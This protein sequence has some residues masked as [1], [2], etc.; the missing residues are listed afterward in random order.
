MSKDSETCIVPDCTR[1]PKYRG[2]CQA[3]YQAALEAVRHGS[4]TWKELEQAGLCRT[5][6]S[7]ARRGCFRLALA[8]LK[9]KQ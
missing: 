4:V 8:E 9:A 1:K 5:K 2:M 6:H 3:C 7:G